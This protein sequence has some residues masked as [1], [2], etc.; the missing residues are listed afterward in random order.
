MRT[1]LTKTLLK[2]PALTFEM[3]Q[4]EQD[5]KGLRQRQQQS[6]RFTQSIPLPVSLQ[7][8]KMETSCNQD[9]VTITIPKEAF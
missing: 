7:A 9:M 2:K 1:I 3:K 5:A 8:D 6:S 4:E